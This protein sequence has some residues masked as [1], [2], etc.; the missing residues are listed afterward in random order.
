MRQVSVYFD[1][2]HVVIC[3]K[4]QADVTQIA[5]W[6]QKNLVAYEFICAPYVLASAH[7]LDITHLVDCQLWNLSTR[8]LVNSLFVSQPRELPTSMLVK[9]INLSASQLSLSFLMSANRCSTA[10]SCGIFF[11]TQTC[12]L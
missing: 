9:L 7:S 8:Q 3:I 4:L 11:S 5:N 10:T 1:A 2:N 6:S 12:F